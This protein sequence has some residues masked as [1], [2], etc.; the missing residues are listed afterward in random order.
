MTD[1]QK[2]EVAEIVLE[3]NA[4]GKRTTYIE[5]AL[6]LPFGT[7]NEWCSGHCDEVDLALLRVIKCYPFMI[8]VADNNF[9]GEF[10]SIAILNE[11]AERVT[12]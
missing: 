5:R 8:E 12:V 10:V 3:L 11:A 7:I 2:K 4:Q 1:D 9:D 6:R